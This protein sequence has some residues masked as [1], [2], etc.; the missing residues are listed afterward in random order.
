MLTYAKALI[1]AVVAGLG[2]IGTALGDGHITYPELLGAAGVVIAAL[3]AVAA[4]PN[5]APVGGPGVRG[6]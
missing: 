6:Y 4:T 5:K 1:A 2:S 3:A